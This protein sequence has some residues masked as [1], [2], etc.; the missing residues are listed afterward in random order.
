[1][2]CWTVMSSDQV[3]PPVR[4]REEMSSE[5]QPWYSQPSDWITFVKYWVGEEISG[6][7]HDC[8]VAYSG[9]SV[10][11]LQPTEKEGQSEEGHR[12]WFD[13]RVIPYVPGSEVRLPVIFSSTDVGSL[14][15]WHSSSVK[16]SPKSGQSSSLPLSFVHSSTAF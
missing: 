1:M 9:P 7:L 8:G 5:A 15:A 6:V 16:S 2:Q 14:Q 10:G 13:S 12:T 11:G 3:K 4:V